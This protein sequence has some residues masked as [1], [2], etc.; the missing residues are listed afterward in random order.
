M[1]GVVEK[2][3]AGSSVKAN[4][5]HSGDFGRYD[6]IGYNRSVPRKDDER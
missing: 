5:Y 2:V 1:F 3:R 4:V 6:S